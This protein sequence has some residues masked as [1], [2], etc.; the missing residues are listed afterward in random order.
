MFSN[1]C[2]RSS[3]MDEVVLNKAIDKCTYLDHAVI[4]LAKN[5]VLNLSSL[6]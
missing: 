4:K 5:M 3:K 1:F 6:M 2:V